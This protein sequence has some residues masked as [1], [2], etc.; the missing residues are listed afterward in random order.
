MKSAD[1]DEGG[2]DDGSSVHHGVVWFICRRQN[3]AKDKSERQG[4]RLLQLCESKDQLRY[5]KKIQPG[6]FPKRVKIDM[7]SISQKNS[8]AMLPSGF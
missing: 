5:Y 4:Q 7:V 2:A 1:L 3:K 6:T 8:A